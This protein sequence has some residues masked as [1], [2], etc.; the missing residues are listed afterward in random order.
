M[1]CW[2][3]ERDTAFW[4]GVGWALVNSQESHATET[5]DI[6]LMSKYFSDKVR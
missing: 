6:K 3:A 4:E 1:S 2:S 5:I